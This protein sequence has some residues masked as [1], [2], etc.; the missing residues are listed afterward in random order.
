LLQRLVNVIDRVPCMFGMA[1]LY[2]TIVIEIEEC[3]IHLKV[4]SSTFGQWARGHW[5]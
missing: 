4:C 2:K 1:R 5:V 3:G